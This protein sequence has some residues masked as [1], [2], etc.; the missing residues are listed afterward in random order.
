MTL[1]DR[2]QLIVQQHL[3]ANNEDAMWL[4]GA[5]GREWREA[6]E[7]CLD[8]VHRSMMREVSWRQWVEMQQQVQDIVKRL[9]ETK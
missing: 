5:K 2:I 4:R 7:R 8:A 6:F 9:L 3:S 1:A